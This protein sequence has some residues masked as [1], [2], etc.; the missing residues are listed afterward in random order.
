MQELTDLFPN[1]EL[2]IQPNAGH[3]PWVDDPHAF[4]ALVGPHLRAQT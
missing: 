3:F 4:V 1:G 2:V